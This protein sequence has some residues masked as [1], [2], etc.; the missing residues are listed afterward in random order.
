MIKILLT[1]KGTK[2]WHNEPE[3][4]ETKKRSYDARAFIG[5]STIGY[6]YSEV[7]K[8]DALGQL[9]LSLAGALE[10]EYMELEVKE[11]WD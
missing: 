2:R 8:E 11:E 6:S 1:T 10:S 7:S 9:I 4:E 5:T 3:T